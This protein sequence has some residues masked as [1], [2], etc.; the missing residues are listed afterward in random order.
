MTGSE[1]DGED[2]AQEVFLTLWR[3]PGAYVPDRGPIRAFLLGVTRNLVL[4]RWRSQR[5]AAAV[6]EL[7]MD[8][9]SCV[10][11]DLLQLERREA[12]ASAVARLPFLQREALV[13]AEYEDLSLAE[14]A[15]VTGAGLPGVKS[16]LSRARQNLRRMLAKLILAEKGANIA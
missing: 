6:E 15:A 2:V 9:L 1:Q 14:I 10:P 11:V 4:K 13:L 3:N 16:R 5:L 7:D 12:I 8:A